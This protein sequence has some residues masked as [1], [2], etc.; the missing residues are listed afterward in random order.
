MAVKRSWKETIARS[1]LVSPRLDRR[2]LRLQ[3]SFLEAAGVLEQLDMK[4]GRQNK[5]R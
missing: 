5:N 3:R 4:G 2:L 1:S